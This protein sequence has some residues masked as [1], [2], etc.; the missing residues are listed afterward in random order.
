M[1]RSHLL[2]FRKLI[3]VKG[4][5]SFSFL[6]AL[7]TRDLRELEKN[8]NGVEFSLLLNAK[9]R[10]VTD[11]LVYKVEDEFLLEVDCNMV[12]KMSKLLNMYKL[13]RNVYI[14]NSS[15]NVN[16]SL[17]KITSNPNAY[18]DPR[19]HTFGT[20]ILC[21]ESTNFCI[22]KEEEKNYH[23]R[24]MIF[25]I[26]EGNSETENELP[27]N[28]NGDLMN[29]I[30]FDKGCYVGQE[31]TARTNF[32]GVVRKR[33]LPLKFESTS[34]SNSTD[35]FNENNKKVGKLIKR[36]DNLGIGIVSVDK[37][38]KEVR[39]NDESVLVLQPEWW[40]K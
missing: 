26:P 8:G 10:I 6:Q 29:G 3:S 12:E 31:L 30:D 36:I 25:A 23:L 1:L 16:F 17:E 28:M 27:L 38:G 14:T 13:R 24:R 9:G 33:L 37:I 32:L 15:K 5:D 20:R 2:S 35:L 18:L 11:L 19:I 7:L 40:R 22:N 39:C 4:N 21:D 34:I